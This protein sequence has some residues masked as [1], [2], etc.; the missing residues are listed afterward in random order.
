M[1]RN[2]KTVQAVLEAVEQDKLECKLENLQREDEDEFYGHLILCI[3]AG[4][5]TGCT[6]EFNLKWRYG[7][8]MPRLTMAGHDTLDALR[9]KAVWAAIKQ[10]ADEAMIPITVTLIQSVLS[11]LSAVL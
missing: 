4:L 1:R 5:V 3:E 6:V 9:S 7:S 10:H 8:T 2:W 11:R